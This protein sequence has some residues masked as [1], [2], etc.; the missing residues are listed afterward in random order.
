[1]TILG[2]SKCKMTELSPV[3]NQ[4]N[5]N[6]TCMLIDAAIPGDKNVVKKEAEKI[7]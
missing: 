1:M 7:L 2:I 5:E 6:R 3:I 4:T